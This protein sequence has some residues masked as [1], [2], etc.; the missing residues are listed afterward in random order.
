MEGDRLK[1]LTF[2]SGESYQSEEAASHALSVARGGTASVRDEAASRTLAATPGAVWGDAH[3]AQIEDFLR[4]IRTGTKPLIDGREGRR[5][6]EVV[7][8]VYRSAR[9]GNPITL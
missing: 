8:A 3:R 6:V 4:A 7:T 9:S 5:P 1:T 2:K